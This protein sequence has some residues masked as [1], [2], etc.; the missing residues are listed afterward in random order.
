MRHRALPVASGLLPISDP[1]GAGQ[2]DLAPGSSQIPS[3]A[4]APAGVQPSLSLSEP[5]SG[6]A[7]NARQPI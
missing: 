6:C 2:V 1:A 7:L 4:V 3:A 5:I